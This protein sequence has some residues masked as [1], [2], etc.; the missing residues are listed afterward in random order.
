M[1]K[2]YEM[3][4][5]LSALDFAIE[6]LAPWNA[7]HK[8]AILAALPNSFEWQFTTGTE[9]MGAIYRGRTQVE[10]ALHNLFESVPDIRY[11]IVQL[12]EGPSHLVMEL[13]VTGHN[14]K[15]GEQ[16]NFQACDILL[17]EDDELIGKRSYRKLISTP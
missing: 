13:L 2:V 17:F 16:L 11:E 6:F 9:P 5:N 15:T 8:Q 10:S 4:N 14:N 12:H 3:K 7:H 1:A